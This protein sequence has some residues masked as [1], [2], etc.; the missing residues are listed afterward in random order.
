M[1]GRKEDSSINVF[2]LIDSI[3]SE[4][5]ELWKNGSRP[6]IE[7]YLDQVPRDA[8]KTLFKNLL[9]AEIRS[10][11]QG[12]ES[13][14]S[15]EYVHR[16]PAFRREVRQA[17]DEPTMMSI[18]QQI[19]ALEHQAELTATID[20]P[21]ANRIGDYEL[22]RELGRGGFGVVYEA[23]HLERRNIVALKTLPTGNDGQEV[24]AD[25]LHRFRKE[26]RSLS[27]FN[28]PNLVGMQTLE[29]DGSQWFFTMDLVNGDDFLAWVRP[30][31]SCDENRLR[32]ALKQ[33]AEGIIALHRRGI[34]HRDLKPS[35]VLIEQDGRVVILDFGLVSEMQN[36]TDLTA[37]RSAMFA[38]TPKYAAPE[39][40]YGKR[41]EASDW[42]AI[43]AMLYEALTGE[44]P[45]T[46][47]DQMELLQ[48]K[49]L[50]DPPQLTAVADVPA[51]LAT[52]VDG[53]LKREPPQRLS[54]AEIAEQLGLDNDTLT[55]GS[56][57]TAGSHDSSVS[58]SEEIE[59]LAEEEEEIDLIGRDVHLA[60]LE[61]ARQQLLISGS[62]VAV[63]IT[64][65]SGEGKSALAEKFLHPFR[66]G[67]EMLVFSGRC[68]D[69]ESVP[70]K[71]IDSIIDPLVRYLRSVSES[72][73]E[74]MLPDDIA[75]LAQL[76]PLLNRVRSIAQRRNAQIRSLDSKQIRY[77]AF[78]ALRELLVTIGQQHAIAILIDDL[79]WGDA[80]SAAALHALLNGSNPPR[81]L[82]LGTYRRDEMQE[83]AF[84]RQW[85][86]LNEESDETVDEREIPLTPLDHR[87]CVAM[88][89]ARA[90][91]SEQQA[92]DVVGRLFEN[93]R[94]NP[95]FLEQ[96]IEG[97]NAGA[98]DWQP[99]PLQE[100]I[101]KKLGRLPRGS[102]QLLDYVAI[103]GKATSSR[104][105]A[106]ISGVGSS[107]QSLLTHMRSE[108]LIRLVGSGEDQ[109]VD[110][111]HDKIR[112]TTLSC[113][114]DDVR[115]E[116][117]RKFA[118]AIESDQRLSESLV[119][120]Y[121]NEPF[122]KQKTPQF[123]TS[124]AFDLAYHFHLSG[125]T[126]A[127]A[128]QLLAGELNFQSYASDEAIEYLSRASEL[129][130]GAEP[131][132]VKARLWHRLA[133][134]SRR[135][136]K[137]DE[138]L[139][140]FASGIEFAEPGIDKAFFYSGIA[141]VHQ[142]RANYDP[143]KTHHDLALAE[144]GRQR[145]Q[146]FWSYPKAAISFLKLATFP[147]SW[148]NRKT[149]N[150]TE[151]DRLEHSILIDFLSYSFELYIPIIEYPA[152][153][154]RAGIFSHQFPPDGFASGVGTVSGHLGIN[155]LPW[156]GRRFAQ[157][158]TAK[159]D[160]VS[161]IEAEGICRIMSG[162]AY[163]HSGDFSLA[164][165]SMKRGI[166]LLIRS[167]S[168]VHAAGA[169]HLHRHLYE[170]IASATAEV[171]IARML[172]SFT[173]S[174]GDLRSSL[175]AHY[176]LSASLARHGQFEESFAAIERANQIW[177]ALKLNLSTPIYLNTRGFVFLQTSNYD[178]ARKLTEFSWIQ[179]IKHLRLMDVCLRGLPWHLECVAGP[180]WAS[181]PEPINKRLVRRRCRWAR[182]L[183][184]LHVKIRPHL[185]RARGRAF[186]ALGKRK[187]SIRNL[188]RGAQSARLLGMKYDLG[189]ALLDLAAVKEEGREENR[190]EA[191]R[192]LKEMESVIPRA[193]SW[194]L[195]DQYDEA[196]V[197]PEFDL[198]AWEQE[199]GP[200]STT[201]DVHA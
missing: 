104:E 153:L 97:F 14:T 195:G 28:H 170:G 120:D 93:T 94:G 190:A 145:P 37:T 57:A 43:G 55:Q 98:E 139:S 118:E 174:S 142:T 33:I 180:K 106:E 96:S 50:E 34:V 128:Y 181:S 88:V 138:S 35:N 82:F 102:K 132:R 125:D 108:R 191:I 90:G 101:T 176:D 48:R 44:L 8:E 164:D 167:G 182:I 147:E 58:A 122:T 22:I 85:I 16:F 64:G 1:S 165:Q 6:R 18:D 127:F 70:F 152:T 26:F 12:S 74:R 197:A 158:A 194:L 56:T 196:V 39:Q 68:Y 124:R 42:Y 87:Q 200:L 151:A 20:L 46:A 115:R 80:D 15:D 95:Y 171:A 183:A 63:W 100:I 116:M 131:A 41:S 78:E 73:L 201:A 49:Q 137:F 146:G 79:Q 187:K 179:A 155:G 77:R 72:K 89:S 17:F 198:Q 5:R 149:K 133:T 109:F 184:L 166:P 10:R 117:H 69:R 126:R 192:L 75:M 119:T 143:A 186:A 129:L 84:H 30:Q 161:D 40:L 140:Q 91:I 112:E 168:H 105:L 99:L 60:Q 65:L 11:R 71:A 157:R 130:R 81:V 135:V 31:G 136:T 51:D 150:I 177:L 52:L 169:I 110:T 156:L 67:K 92:N 113:I 2:E 47:S 54:S 45:F 21:A 29:V 159:L 141:T 32:Q 76:F 103:A 3:C 193:E 185:F 148:L 175:W 162:V 66:R 134:S 172:V 86:R 61:S 154:M 123:S 62:P 25:R 59:P 38:G 24:N 53:L 189:K 23:R 114:T 163:I 144:I 111:W 27:E 160:L 9:Y 19:P 178:E 7:S 121:L 13:P 173:N 188:E 36:A 199:H 4:F 107:A 83:S